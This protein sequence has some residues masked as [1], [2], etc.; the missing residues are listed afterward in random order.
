M[1]QP[2]PIAASPGRKAVFDLALFT[3]S[4]DPAPSPGAKGFLDLPPELRLRIY[5]YV[6]SE[7]V[8]YDDPEPPPGARVLPNIA[9]AITCHQV[10]KE[11]IT[12]ARAAYHRYPWTRI[13]DTPPSSSINRCLEIELG[14]DYPSSRIIETLGIDI[15]D[16]FD[17]FSIVGKRESGWSWGELWS[18]DN[19]WYGREVRHQITLAG[20][21]TAYGWQGDPEAFN[22]RAIFEKKMERTD[23]YWKYESKKERSNAQWQHP[24]LFLEHIHHSACAPENLQAWKKDWPGSVFYY[25]PRGPKQHELGPIT[26]KFVNATRQNAVAE[27]NAAGPKPESR[28]L[29]NEEAG[30]NHDEDASSNHD[31]EPNSNHADNV[32]GID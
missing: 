15:V 21:S 2:A 22:R 11:H 28:L 19:G 20:G 32:N 8:N 30:S 12:G 23:F 16:S 6:T 3:K 1:E 4:P 29:H 14:S 27:A 26:F 9:L 17:L 5:E 10:Y 24:G 31:G 18:S 13:G 25:R 7:I